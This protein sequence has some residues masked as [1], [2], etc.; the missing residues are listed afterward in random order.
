MDRP[1]AYPARSMLRHLTTAWV[2]NPMGHIKEWSSSPSPI[3]VLTSCHPFGHSFGLS[4]CLGLNKGHLVFVSSLSRPS[5]LSSR[6]RRSC[7]SWLY[8]AFRPSFLGH[9]CKGRREIPPTVTHEW[10]QWQGLCCRLHQSGRPL[11]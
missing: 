10:R 3:E 5:R 7:I 11:C 2:F 9:F 4:S 6:L 8:T 1:L